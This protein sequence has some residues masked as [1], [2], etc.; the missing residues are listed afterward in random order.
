MAVCPDRDD[1]PEGVIQ[2][3]VHLTKVP[4]FQSEG[5]PPKRHKWRSHVSFVPGPSIFLSYRPDPP[6]PVR[7]AQKREIPLAAMVANKPIR[8][9]WATIE[10]ARW[11]IARKLRQPRPQPLV[12][13]KR[14]QT[15]PTSRFR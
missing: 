10:R 5:S 4:K 3:F 7:L 6:G 9:S 1:L 11:L 12:D 2:S 8:T 14:L 13:R 15:M